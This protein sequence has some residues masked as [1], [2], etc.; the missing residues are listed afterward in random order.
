MKFTCNRC[1]TYTTNLKAN[2]ARHMKRKKP[3]VRKEIHRDTQEKQLIKKREYACS[4][5]NKIFSTNSSMNRHIRIYCK[6]AKLHK[7]VTDLERENERLRQQ[8]IT[9]NHTTNNI[10]NNTIQNNNIIHI[11]A[12]GSEDLQPIMNKIPILLKHFPTT[13]VTDLICERYYDPDHPENK[14][15]KITSRKEKWAQIYNGKEW[16]I[17]KKVDVLMDVLQKNFE[18]LDQ[19]YESK[20]LQIPDYLRINW[21]EMRES[22]NDNS[23]PTKD[24][25]LTTEEILTNQNQS[26]SSYRTVFNN[27]D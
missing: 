19:Y 16:E 2:L 18:L 7:R 23:F 15:V 5:C 1:G 13:A 4:H 24:M 14:T 3:C 17:Q 20:N 6:E 25:L 11:H 9:T 27:D 12:Y 10:Q 8:R 26:K 22:W 21:E